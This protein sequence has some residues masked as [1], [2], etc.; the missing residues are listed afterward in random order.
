MLKNEYV[1]PACLYGKYKSLWL[2]PRQAYAHITAT[3]TLTYHYLNL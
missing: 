3:L 2:R 1:I